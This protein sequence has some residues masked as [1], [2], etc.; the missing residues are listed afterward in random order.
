[1]NFELTR[2]YTPEPIPKNM[3][4]VSASDQMEAV[5]PGFFEGFGSALADIVPNAINTTASSFSA[6]VD[7]TVGEDSVFG[8]NGIKEQLRNSAVEAQELGIRIEDPDKFAE[9]QYQGRLASAR[10]FRERAKEE[11]TPS[12]SAVG[13]A[14]QLVFGVGTEL[15]KLAMA[16]PFGSAAPAVYGANAG[17]QQAQTLMD[18]GVDEDTARNAGFV[19]A[20]ASTIGVKLPMAF[21]NTRFQSAAIGAGAN[22]GLFSTEQGLISFILNNADYGDVA[23]RFDPTDPIGLAINALSGA[24]FGFVGFRGAKVEGQPKNELVDAVNEK[25]Q[26]VAD[27]LTH[28]IVDAARVRWLANS[29]HKDQPVPD[30]NPALFTKSKKTEAEVRQRLDN[31]EKVEISQPLA[32]EERILQEQELLLEKMH[33]V[34]KNPLGDPLE[35]L[36]TIGDNEPITVRRG[37][38]QSGL[39][40]RRKAYNEVAY[41]KGEKDFGLVKIAIKHV[42]EETEEL[43]V[44]D[45]D[46]RMVPRIVRDYDPVQVQQTGNKSWRVKTDEGREIVV[47]TKKMKVEDDGEDTLLSVYIQ[48]P[49][50]RRQNWGYSNKKSVVTNLSDELKSPAEDTAARL[51]MLSSRPSG[52]ADN[53]GWVTTQSRDI[54]DR[55]S[56]I[57]HIK[58][59]V[60]D[61]VERAK[62]FLGGEEAEVT[63]ESLLEADGLNKEFE[64]PEGSLLKKELDQ[65]VEVRED[66]TEITGRQLLQEEFA[67]ADEVE[68]FSDIMEEAAACVFRNNGI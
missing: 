67:F 8:M 61:A 11:Y 44:T 33:D 57:D 18:E 62:R 42:A 55:E 56:S 19:T 30:E 41:L 12:E 43:K 39:E 10:R 51:P 22:T 68:K 16:L 50:K 3:P 21:G 65:V 37:K 4:V 45:D 5:E 15:T 31:G 60:T 32:S 66:G 27:G 20:L 49:K 9:E 58:G 7:A 24:G 1:M 48:D 34:M 6:A 46:L 63:P 23:K 40:G 53:A 2:R 17:I 36:M 28:R 25:V 35:L 26:K 13:T 52:P 29:I 64:S 14:G 59:V 47:A 54:T 38:I